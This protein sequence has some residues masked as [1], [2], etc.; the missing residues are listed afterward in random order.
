MQ[1]LP[2]TF[3]GENRWLASP[4]GQESLRRVL[5]AYS[6]HNP[7]VGYCQSMN[8]VAAVLLLVLEMSEED[9]FWLMVVLLDGAAA[10]L[11]SLLSA[12]RVSENSAARSTEGSYRGHFTVTASAEVRVAEG[13]V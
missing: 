9:T 10:S 1:D 13:W 8:Y 3:P 4:E 5:V 11:C 12:L 2:R 7:K 6:A